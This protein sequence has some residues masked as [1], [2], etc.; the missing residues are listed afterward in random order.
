MSHDGGPPKRRSSEIIAS[1]QEIKQK[2]H[3]PDVKPHPKS[4]DQLKAELQ[5]T[6]HEVTVDELCELVGTDITKGMTSDAVAKRQE[7]EGRNMLTP[8]K[9]TPEWIKVLGE[10]WGFFP[11]LLWAGSILCFV[12]YSLQGSQ[13]NLYLGIVLA[14]VV[15]ITGLFSYFQNRKSSQLME[16]FKSMMPSLTTVMRDGEPSELDAIELVRGD[17]LYLKAGDKVPADI[18]IVKCS[19]DMQVDN[20]SLTGES[21]PQKRSTECTHENPLETKNLAFFGTEIPKGSCTGIV[22]KVGDSTVMGRI[23]RLTTV[24]G[25]EETPIAREI[26][27]FVKIVSAV[28]IFLGITF[29]IAGLLIGTDLITN[30][31]FMIGIIVA[32]VP[33]GLLATVTVCLARTANRMATKS[34]LVKN[35][36]GVETLGSTS[37]ICS[38]KTGT[39]TQ[40]MMTVANLV[41]DNR[42]YDAVSSMHDTSNIDESSFAFQRLRRCATLCNNAKWDRNSKFERNPTTGKVDTSKPVPF[43]DTIML[44][45]GSEEHRVLWKALGDASESALVK[46]CQ[47]YQDIEEMRNQFEKLAE[48]P[49]NSANKY[50]VSVHKQPDSPRH[51]LVMKGAPERIISRCSTIVLNGENVEF[52]DMLRQDL[53]GLQVELSKQGLRVLGFCELEL[54]EEYS[55]DHHYDTDNPNFPLGESWRNP[56]ELD[57]T[58]HPKPDL[59]CTTPL[60]FL[61]LFAMIDPPRPQVPG[62]V[63]LCKTAGIRVIMVTGD[64]PITAQAIAKKVGIIWSETREDIEEVN[65]A[66]SLKEGDEGWRDPDFAPAMVVPGWDISLD[67]PVEIWDDILDHNEVVFARTSPQQKLIIVENCQRRGDVVAVTGDGVNDAPALRKA[68]IGVAMGI[69]GSDVSKEA[70]D[71]IL[72]DDNFASIVAGIEEGRLIFDN[73][74][75]SIAYTLSSN[76]PEIGPFLSFIVLQIPL[77]LSTVLILC[78]DLGTDMVPAISMAWENAESDIMRRPPRDSKTDHL[79]SRKLICFSY[80]QIGMIQA[81]AGFYTYFVVMG[82]YGYPASVLFGTSSFDNWGK[83]Q[84]FCKVTNGVYRNL[85]G[86]SQSTYDAASGYL[87]WDP[88]SDGEVVDCLF[89]SKNFEGKGAGS[90]SDR[91]NPF[92]YTF[93]D[94]TAGQRVVTAESVDALQQAGYTEYIPWRARQSPFFKTKWLG[95]TEAD[96]EVPGL[97]SD[98]SG[99]IHFSYQPVG[100]WNIDF[101]SVTDENAALMSD[102]KPIMRDANF[103]GGVISTDKVY[104]KA[105]FTKAAAVNVASRMCQ[106]E[107]LHHAQTAYFVSIVVVQWA[108]LVICKTRMNSLYMQGM[109]NPAMNFGLIFET[110][111][112]GFLCFLPGLATGLG[113][114]PIRLLHWVPAVPFSIVIFLYDETRKYLMRR[115][116]KIT[117]SDD[118]GQLFRDPCWLERFTY[119]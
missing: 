35:L 86:D 113:T 117:Q 36:E 47:G 74:K 82:D 32:N 97:S 72:L 116:T 41:Y 14:A 89:P 60:S 25:Q 10:L 15:V 96:D 21:E 77:P 83:Q 63:Q 69:M 30:L 40:N 102:V 62:A 24:T 115:D 28:A 37:C 118:T 12:A 43:Q 53:E 103:T 78:I 79:V 57:M 8:P 61:G 101:S 6:E 80:L 71:M 39:L 52:T 98:V 56:D 70:A 108:D 16:S 23:A 13:D 84:L 66:N 87:F 107:T 104:S 7:A 2:Y 4:D 9:S 91:F 42:I 99:T 68:N 67:T 5:M 44:G 48:I 54:S 85:A 22:V 106:K 33:E 88:A 112:A 100:S 17:V 27:Y 93:S 18:R 31:V 49:F 109:I 11:A 34:V 114:R 105:T 92:A 50:Q 64:H 110:I 119:Y 73:L 58:K 38:D 1:A 46:F 29:F 81:L 55:D 95:I 94:F 65:A 19:D 45:D 76:I 90:N 75:K 59:R 111:L 3:S 26:H 51:L 20:S